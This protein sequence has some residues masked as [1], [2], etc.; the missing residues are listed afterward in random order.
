MKISDASILEPIKCNMTGSSEIE[1]A[2]PIR[3]LFLSTRASYYLRCHGN[4]WRQSVCTRDTE[5]IISL[6]E[7]HQVE[8]RHDCR[9]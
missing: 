4:I 9:V 5:C 1:L 8:R 3:N 6:S 2:V 7:A